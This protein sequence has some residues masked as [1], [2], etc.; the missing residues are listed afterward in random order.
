MEANGSLL[1][2]TFSGVWSLP[3]ISL[4]GRE[5][6]SYPSFQDVRFILLGASERRVMLCNLIGEV[7][8]DCTLR[9]SHCI[10]CSL[11]PKVE[12]LLRKP[13][14]SL[15][16]PPLWPCHSSVAYTNTH[17][18]TILGFALTSLEVSERAVERRLCW[19]QQPRTALGHHWQSQ[20]TF[21]ECFWHKSQCTHQFPCTISFNSQ[22]T[23]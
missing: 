1:L 12:L 3:A 20:L 4:L 9:G 16:G 8:T 21:I 10:S 18:T 22:A 19:C 5:S 14:F 2:P 15:S 11:S 7:G 23:L 17:M 6:N 13:S